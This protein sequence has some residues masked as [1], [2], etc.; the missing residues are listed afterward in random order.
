M[1]IIQAIFLGLIEGITEFLPVSSTAHLI[2]TSRALGLPQNEFISFFEVFIQSGAILAVVLLYFRFI[3]N[4]K[5]LIVNLAISFVP[6]AIVG[7]LLH[8][9]I[10]T[11]FF[12]ST[13]LIAVSLLSV[14]LIFIVLEYFIKEGKLNLRKKLQDMTYSDAFLIGSIQSTAVVPGVSRAGAVIVAMILLRYKRYDAALYSF[15]L[16]VP[17][18]LAASGFDLL[19]TDLSLLANPD[20]IIILTLGFVISFV[21]AIVVVKWLIRY[22]QKNSLN[23]FGVYRIILAIILITLSL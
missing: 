21:S 5:S 11:V 20:N 23:L 6:T 17:T 10:K 7:L 16:A 9:I 2:L 3:L 15:L 13:Y 22:L 12:N 19:K 14:G 4:N 1:T 18:I 8:D